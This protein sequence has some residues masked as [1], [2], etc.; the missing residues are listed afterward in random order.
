VGQIFCFQVK[1][2]IPT[3]DVELF[4][5]SDVKCVQVCTTSHHT[6]DSHHSEWQQRHKYQRCCDLPKL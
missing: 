1:F 2:V 3:V 6:D 4:V 5:T